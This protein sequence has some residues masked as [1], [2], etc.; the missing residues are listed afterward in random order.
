MAE[1]DGMGR[2]KLVRACS[3]CASGSGESVEGM[4]RT[5]PV[6]LLSGCWLSGA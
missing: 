3:P 4:G 1:M 5:E 2:T 6:S